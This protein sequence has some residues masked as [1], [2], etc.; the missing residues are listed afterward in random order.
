MFYQEKIING[1][2]CWRGTPDGAFTP[3][4]IEQLSGRVKDLEAAIS[5][6]TERFNRIGEI[7]AGGS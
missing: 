3:F 7:I 5:V 1:V 6:Y 2:L 4:T